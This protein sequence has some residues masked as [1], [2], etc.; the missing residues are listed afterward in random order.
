[1]PHRILSEAELLEAWKI[2]GRLLLRTLRRH[3]R[4]QWLGQA[5]CIRVLCEATINADQPGPRKA[6]TI[7]RPRPF[8]ISL[9]T[10]CRSGRSLRVQ[11]S[12]TCMTIL[13]PDQ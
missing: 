10:Y 11:L 5:A 1:M 4:E 12:H 3:V 7:R 6:S 13:A 8:P 2:P 9:I